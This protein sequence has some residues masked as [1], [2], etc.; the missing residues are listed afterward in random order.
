MKKLTLLVI[1]AVFS[2]VLANRTL[3]NEGTFDL[4]AGPGQVGECFVA[5]VY[6]DASYHLLVSCRDLP[7]AISAERTRYVLWRQTGNKISRVGEIVAGKLSA[8]VSEKLE[9]LFVIAETDAYTSKPTDNSML[10]G[11]L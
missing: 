2:F 9:S 3:A 10:A 6:V 5:S 1:V 4:I 11:N 7:V 8:N